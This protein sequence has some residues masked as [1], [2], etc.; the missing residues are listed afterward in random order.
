MGAFVTYLL[1]AGIFLLFFYL[2]NRLLLAK[3]T[4]HRF[5]RIVWLLI[6]PL[7]LLLPF[8]IPGSFDPLAWFGPKQQQG[9]MLILPEGM[10]ATV[11]DPSD[12]SFGMARMVQW[13]LLVYFT[14]MFICFLFF[15]ISYIKLAAILWKNK[16][17]GKEAAFENLLN[18]CKKLSRVTGKVRLLVHSQETAPFSWMRYIVVS[19]KDMTE[20]G[21]DIL[22]HELSHVRKGHSWDLILTDLLI[23][24]QWFNPAAWLMKQSI[25]QVQEFQADDAVLKAGINAKQYQLLLIKKAVGTRRYSMVNSFNHSKLK[26]RITMMWKKKSSKWAFAKCMYA[27]PLAFIAIT[28]FATPEISG[29]LSE[30]SSVKDIKISLQQSIKPQDPPVPVPVPPPAVPIAE[31][32]PQADQD[33][34]VPLATVETKPLFAN[35]EGEEAFTR[36]VFEHIKYPEEAK[37]KGIQGRVVAAF[38]LNHEGIVTNVQILRGV[39]PLL[40]AEAIRVLESSPKWERPGVYKGKKAN[41][42]Y[43]FPLNFSLNKDKK[44]EASVKQSTNPEDLGLEPAIFANGKG[45]N[46]FAFWVMQ[47]VKYPEDAK[48]EG[49]GGRLLVSY[50]LSKEGTITQVEIIG[51]VHASIDAEVLRVIESSPKWEKPAMKEGIPVNVSYVM[52]MI[53]S[54]RGND[55]DSAKT[56]KELKDLKKL[57]VLD[58]FIVVGYGNQSDV[59]HDVTKIPKDVLVIVDGKEVEDL[60]ELDPDDIES[61]EVLKDAAAIEKYGEKGRKGVII[62]TRK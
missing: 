8:C 29:R 33:T 37:T 59:K 22:I 10:T 58:G 24:F 3:E 48:N 53:F 60:Q 34:L 44:D 51:G 55:R 2:F 18:Q 39:H 42:R 25:Q 43:N 4:F 6:I 5:N 54:L 28:A 46:E 1:K 32:V 26:K 12:G 45:E 62:V 36:W 50:E 9:Q 52:P 11:M 35:G 56:I 27:L 17:N 47:H 21:K 13:I 61:I 38:V 57:Q 40:D 15:V 14:G 16:G 49:A 19:E 7:S 41:V 31:A 30:I 20:D 23:L